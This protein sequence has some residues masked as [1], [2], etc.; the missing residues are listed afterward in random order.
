SP[1]GARNTWVLCFSRRNALAWTIR[2]RSR[3]KAVRS[4]SGSSSRSRPFD[5]EASV[6]CGESVSRSICS[7]RSRGVGAVTRPWY[8][9]PPTRPGRGSA[10]EDPVVQVREGLAEVAAQTSG[11]APR[12]RVPGGRGV[13]PDAEV[14]GHPLDPQVVPGIR[15]EE[16]RPHPVRLHVGGGGAEALERGVSDGLGHDRARRKAPGDQVVPPG[17]RLGRDVSRLAGAE[18][19]HGPGPVLP[20]QELGLLEPPGEHRRGPA[21]VLGGPQDDDRVDALDPARVVLVRRPPDRNERDAHHAHRDRE[22][23]AGQRDDGMAADGAHHANLTTRPHVTRI[24]T[25]AFASPT[26]AVDRYD[27]GALATAPNRYVPGWT[28]LVDRYSQAEAPPAS[29]G[30]Q[31]FTHAPGGSVP[32]PG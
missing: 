19:D 2:S 22:Q 18:H 21:V 3:W 11:L 9:R 23:Q 14:R 27:P 6:A 26:S 16:R 5:P 4:G 25:P 31:V 13:S 10:P 29:A 15:D 8:P 7:V 1:S 24:H 20:I 32:R 30:Q 12:G 17:L 28:P